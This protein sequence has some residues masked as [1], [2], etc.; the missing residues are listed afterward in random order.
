MATDT[1]DPRRWLALALICAAQF[2][3]VLDVAFV[4]VA[5]PSIQTDLDFSRQGLQWVVSAYALTFGGFLLLGGRMADLLGRRR[6]FVAGLGLFTVASLLCGLAWTSE[7][8]VGA[9]A[10]QGL[11]AAIVSPAALSIITTIFREGA[12]RNQALGIW[13][14]LSG[15]GAAAG[16]LL[17]GV[18]TDSLGWEWIFF[19]NLP[20]GLAVVALA[21]RLLRES[22]VEGADR[23]FDVTG[24]LSV[25]ASLVLLVYAVVEAP[26][27]GWGSFRTIGLLLLSAA[28]MATFVLIESRS[29]AP[30]M[31]LTIFRLRTLTGANVV[32]FLIGAS[33]FAMFFILSLYMQQVLGWS[34]LKSGLAY[35]A[36]ALTVIVA[37][38]VASQLVTRIGVKTVLAIGL[39]I[40]TVG[41]VYFTQVSV[42]GTYLGDLFPGFII[43]GIGLG[44][45][46]VPV[47]IAALQG[48]KE[49][50][51]GLASGLINTTQ[52]I[53][54]A[55]G[56][57]IVA[58]VATSRAD[59][60]IEDAN[61]ARSAIP[62]AQTEG[63]QLAFAVAGGFAALGLLV[64]LLVIRR[65]AAPD[66]GGSAPLPAT[67]P[68]GR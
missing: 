66:E 10:L 59:G 28:L 43:A 30:L 62:E 2:M 1:P 68:A 6:I 8:L 32:G 53:G 31:P 12:E 46:F 44:F 25:T 41:L 40:A 64:T 14:A 54:G 52:Q 29:Q 24:A 39:G 34:A 63:F 61:G 48:I 38:G 45:S 3:V 11:G 65:V 7:I 16:V 35:L 67:S 22:R 4:N 26:E 51:A 55:V 58:T 36:V 9:R 23:R 57:A 49:S 42:D 19:V 33:I 5:L 56:V 27:A 37:A 50:E 20:I 60:L 18:L 21:P 15:S 13:G 17:G 47:S